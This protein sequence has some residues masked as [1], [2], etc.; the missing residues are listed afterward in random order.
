MYLFFYYDLRI[1]KSLVFACYV[2]ENYIKSTRSS[3]KSSGGTYFIEK[4]IAIFCVTPKKEYKF[5]C[6]IYKNK[7]LV[8]FSFD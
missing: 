6:I 5:A 2:C 4:K 8:I 3:Q 7:I 1:R